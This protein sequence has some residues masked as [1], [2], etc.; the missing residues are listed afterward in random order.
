MACKGEEPPDRVKIIPAFIP[1][2]AYLPRAEKSGGSCGALSGTD[3]AIDFRFQPDALRARSFAL[4]RM[5][6][7]QDEEMI[8]GN[9]IEADLCFVS[10]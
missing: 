8:F 10:F 7:K 5:T 6:Q 3:L 1:W 2:I 4:L 9:E